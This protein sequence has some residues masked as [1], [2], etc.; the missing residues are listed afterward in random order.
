M[1]QS[2]SQKSIFYCLTKG[3]KKDQ[4][5]PIPW[6]PQAL[7]CESIIASWPSLGLSSLTWQSVIASKKN[8]GVGFSNTI[9][10]VW[11]NM[12]HHSSVCLWDA[13]W[14]TDGPSQGDLGKDSGNYLPA[15]QR[16][17]CQGCHSTGAHSAGGLY[18][19][20]GFMSEGFGYQ[21]PP[22]PGSIKLQTAAFVWL[23]RCLK[24][25]ITLFKW[26]FPS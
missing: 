13:R 25:V 18:L 23:P 20:H 7:C 16:H 14:L 17:P 10:C 11:T 1:P 8:T 15:Y 24:C 6:L 19:P 12:L 21:P 3:R 22:L 26:L 2:L 9:S 4:Q 5:Q